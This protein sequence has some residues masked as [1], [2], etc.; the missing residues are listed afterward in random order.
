MI[1]GISSQPQRW[2]CPAERQP[3]PSA[4]QQHARIRKAKAN[5]AAQPPPATPRPAARDPN[6]APCC[7]Q[8]IPR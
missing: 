8:P 4:C 2:I 5:E 7:Y 1:S 3:S 6:D